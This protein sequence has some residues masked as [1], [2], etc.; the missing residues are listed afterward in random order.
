MIPIIR[1]DL[2]FD[3]VEA[4]LRQ[5]FA[6]GILTNGPYLEAFEAA[7]AE[8]VG[9][10]HAVATTSATTALHLSLV[11]LGVGPGDEVIVSDLSFPATA[12]VVMQAGAAPVFADCA[13]HSAAL[14]VDHVESL[15]NK[16]TA[17]IL[18]VDPFG[19][20]APLQALERLVKRH[21]LM[22]LEDAA[23]ALGAATAGRP[24]G[25]WGQGGCF[26]FHPRKVATAGEGGVV[27]TDDGELARRLR[28][29]RSHGGE[30]ATQGQVGLRFVEHGFNYRL[31]E[32]QAAMGLS[33]VRRLDEIVADR[34]VTAAC[35]DERLRG[36]PEV[37]LLTPPEGEVWTYQS[38]VVVLDAQVDRN[39]VVRSLGATGIETTLGTYAQH[40][41]PA[42][43]HLGWSPGDLPRSLAMQ[44]QSLTLPLL[45]RMDISLV[46]Q[47]VDALAAAV[48]ANR[49]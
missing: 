24:C 29:L 1:P 38:Y 49:S 14:D 21:G 17:A 34:R 6:S 47:V 35:Y 7:V 15:L 30:A 36:V 43:G 12:N 19:Q 32:V 5:I 25:S 41:Q 22:L 4:D 39:A 11:A 2:A 44:Q 46:D 48:I 9:V 28:R 20:P 13:P 10:A 37:R 16:S 23:C 8:R 40:A 27:T 18:A 42:F 45:P 26:S 3:D 31:S 33:Q